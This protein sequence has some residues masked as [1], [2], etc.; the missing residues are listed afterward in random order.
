MCDR[1]VHFC[2]FM[3]CLWYSTSSS[4][5]TC[6][7]LVLEFRSR[8][9]MYAWRFDSQCLCEF[10][11]FVTMYACMYGCMDSCH[12]SCVFCNSQHLCWFMRIHVIFDE[13]V[14]SPTLVVW[15]GAPSIHVGHPSRREHWEACHISC[16]QYSHRLLQGPT[17]LLC[18]A[19]SPRQ[20]CHVTGP[21]TSTIHVY[22]AVGWKVADVNILITSVADV[23][24]SYLRLHF[25]VGL[26]M[27]ACRRETLFS[28]AFALLTSASGRRWITPFL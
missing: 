19:T 23:N 1:V 16:V 15:K 12:I 28:S 21:A 17:W 2:F 24:N 26:F 4:N 13:Y 6:G 5:Y 3:W 22:I 20:P 27:S 7:I 8:I 14:L 11:W 9:C 10:L 18:V 25:L